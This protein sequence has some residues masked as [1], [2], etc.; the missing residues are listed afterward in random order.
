[1]LGERP[2]TLPGVGQTIEVT[3]D[4]VLLPP[5][6]AAL[7]VPPGPVP[8]AAGTPATAIAIPYLQWDNRDGGPM[9]VWLPRADA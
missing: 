3:A 2:V 5:A 8:A 6:T 7:S 1:V 4:D 9:R